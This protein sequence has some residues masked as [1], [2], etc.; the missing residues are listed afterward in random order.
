MAKREKLHNVNCIEEWGIDEIMFR[1]SLQ[2]DM[3]QPAFRE[4][5]KRNLS[6]PK[7][8][9][10]DLDDKKIYKV[11]YPNDLKKMATDND[12]FEKFLDYCIDCGL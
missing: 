5:C 11:F 3:L 6:F 10:Q 7:I 1:M 9:I 12:S 8:T 2:M 4:A